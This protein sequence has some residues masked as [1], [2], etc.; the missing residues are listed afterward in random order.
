MRRT[1][2]CGSYH[3][4]GEGL[5]SVFRE[6]ESHGV[7][8]LSPIS[9]DFVDRMEPVVRTEHEGTLSI[10]ELEK[11]HLRGMRD[12]DFVWLHCPGGHIGLSASYEIGFAHA[13]DIPVFSS[14]LPQDEMLASQVRVVAS[15]FHALEWGGWV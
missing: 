8:I 5:A 6:I 1:V 7:R 12:A 4:D 13:L 11:F 3:R 14:E 15:V 9:I 10:Y 2:I